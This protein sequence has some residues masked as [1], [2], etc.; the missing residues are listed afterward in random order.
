MKLAALISGGK[1]SMLALHKAFE[2]HEIA[3]IVSVIPENP[4]S[5]MFH[6]FNLHLLD[7]ISTS[8]NLPVFKIPTKG[9]EEDEVEDLKRNLEIL[10]VDGI[11][12]GG[13]ESEYQKKRFEK[14]CSALRIE[15]I[16]P[17]WKCNVLEMMEEVVS[18]F[19]TII[20]SVSAMGLDERYIGRRLDKKILNELKILKEKYGLHIAGE[21]GEYETLVLDAPLYR[22]RIVI[23]NSKKIWEGCSGYLVVK[24]FRLEEKGKSSP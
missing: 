1:D 9:E 7:A 6:T 22:K 24:E 14:I 11:V 21:G 19:E 12:I 4:H 2:E 10:D 18:K 13:I 23:E 3:C 20:V 17:L 16:A 15:L 8:L 5:Y